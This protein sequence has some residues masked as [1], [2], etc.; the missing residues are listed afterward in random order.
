MSLGSTFEDS[1]K[2]IQLTNSTALDL[3]RV[4]YFASLSLEEL[5]QQWQLSCT[6]S[7]RRD[8]TVDGCVSKQPVEIVNSKVDLYAVNT[9]QET[10]EIQHIPSIGET[11][12]CDNAEIPAITTTTTNTTISPVVASSRTFR[13]RRDIQLRPYT[14]DRMKHQSLLGGKRLSGPSATKAT[15][16]SLL[17]ATSTPLSTQDSF[18]LGDQ[19][20]LDQV[21]SDSDD[22]YDVFNDFIDGLDLDDLGI[23]D[24]DSQLSES[25]QIGNIK[26][27]GN[28]GNDKGDCDT[29]GSDHGEQLFRNKRRR[30]KII[31]ED[32]DNDDDDDMAMAMDSISS[33]TTTPDTSSDQI[34]NNN[35]GVDDIF[36]LPSYSPLPLKTYHKKQ[37]SAQL[38]TYKRPKKKKRPY[39][40]RT[41]DTISTSTG[42]SGISGGN[43]KGATHFPSN[44]ASPPG[45]HAAK[46]IFDMP[47]LDEFDK[48]ARHLN[49]SNPSPSGRHAVKDIFDLPSLGEFDSNDDTL[50]TDTEVMDD[51]SYTHGGTTVE[52]TLSPMTVK[53]V[54]PLLKRQKRQNQGHGGD[55]DDTGFIVDE[56]GGH[57]E[58]RRNTTL[59]EVRK[60]KRTLKGVLPRSF[61]KVFHQ[62]LDQEEQDVHRQPRA[63]SIRK[64]GVTNDQHDGTN[65][66]NSMDTSPIRSIDNTIDIWDIDDEIYDT[67]TSSTN[68]LSSPA[69]SRFDPIVTDTASSNRRNGM[70]RTTKMS[71][72]RQTL[73]QVIARQNQK[74]QQHQEQEEQ[75]QQQWRQSVYNSFTIDCGVSFLR[76]GAICGNNMNYLEDKTFSPFS[77]H[78]QPLSW[79]NVFGQRFCA[80]DYY[81]G[82]PKVM[83]L[84]YRGFQH[85]L[86]T[87]YNSNGSTHGHQKHS[88]DTLL[89]F[90]RFVSGCLSYQNNKCNES[91]STDEMYWFMIG[92]M[93]IFILRVFAMVNWKDDMEWSNKGG[94]GDTGKT[95]FGRSS[96]PLLL[97]LFYCVDWAFQLQRSSSSTSHWTLETTMRRM[98]WYLL[99]LGPTSASVVPDETYTFNVSDPLVTEA[100]ILLLRSAAI[101]NYGDELLWPCLQEFMKMV[102]IS[103][104]VKLD[105][106]VNSNT[107]WKKNALVWQWIM[108]IISLQQLQKNADMIVIVK[109]NTEMVANSHFCDL[110][111]QLLNDIAQQKS[112]IVTSDTTPS[113][114]SQTPNSNSQQTHH[115]YAMT[116]I[117]ITFCRLHL[118]MM[119]F[120][121]MWDDKIIQLLYNLTQS[122]PLQVFTGDPL[123]PQRLRHQLIDTAAQYFPVFFTNYNG[124]I[125]DDQVDQTDTCGILFIKIL[126][127]GLR[128]FVKM[129]IVDSDDINISKKRRKQLRRCLVR[130]SP[131]Y[132]VVT[133]S[134]TRSSSLLLSTMVSKISN[135]TQEIADPFVS[136]SYHYLIN[137]TILHA[138]AQLGKEDNC[139]LNVLDSNIVLQSNVEME[140]AWAQDIAGLVTQIYGSIKSKWHLD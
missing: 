17:P 128:K 111:Y 13:Q 62:Q 51:D 63:S 109:V 126:S 101:E 108:T 14:V 69:H 47:S 115:F 3:D 139:G 50:G 87:W 86:I 73:E 94:K 45:P 90:L 137:M 71:P 31:D 127:N 37:T 7:P 35:D 32:D 112:I 27:S 138:T 22:D 59:Q 116:S 29:D 88:M 20:Y 81:A 44:T 18:I 72:T 110:I 132:L 11:I 107:I 78:H 65:D 46:N 102:T 135:H 48:G 113:T 36:A 104:S 41:C 15:R 82:S 70:N 105:G 60:Y 130:L 40:H 54:S 28:G 52:S 100:W 49:S 64:L 39:Q 16:A 93:D 106:I 4:H 91:H 61:V 55:S 98:L 74:E 43:G 114:T 57:E 33:I 79:A 75:L 80:E 85:F 129:I 119:R 96:S 6:S 24:N 134:S 8:Q 95:T 30:F 21:P 58:R 66:S 9:D 89:N 26:S 76:P 83:S 34:N 2:G 120:G 92:E 118:L 117:R 19:S 56:S 103:N 97:V 53:Q 23:C 124:S 1:D 77:A 25:S 12:P 5:S 133:G 140:K 131:S 10:T 123:Q 42:N 84:F 125:P 38:I 67:T 121:W 99:S 68:I 122:F 136:F